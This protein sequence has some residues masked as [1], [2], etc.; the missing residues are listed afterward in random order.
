MD[1]RKIENYLKTREFGRELVCLDTTAST[2][3]DAK[4]AAANGCSH[5]CTVVSDEQTAGRGRL[6]H[7]WLS[8]AGL[9]IYVSLVLKPCVTTSA[10]PQ[11]PVICAIA[12]H[13][14][15][16]GMAPSLSLALKWPNDL[17]TADTHRK[18]SGILCEGVTMKDRSLAVVVGIGINVNSSLNDFSDD[19]RAT[20]TSLKMATGQSWNR[21]QI[22]AAFLNRFE[23]VFDGWQNAANLHPF[24]DYWNRHDLLTGRDIAIL[25]DDK[26]E[27]GVSRGIDDEGRLLLE[28]ADGVKLIHAGDVH[29]QW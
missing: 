27:E 22:L 24:M 11:I 20:A 16:A 26:T 23:I 8:P 14:A 28:T 15:L 9:N 4:K 2:N 13:Q 25:Q 12:L 10:F 29:L 19:L 21:E 5:G 1:K 17:L 3:L 7:A 6:D 18:I